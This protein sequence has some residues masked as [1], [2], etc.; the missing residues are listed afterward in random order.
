MYKGP[1]LYDVDI[2]IRSVNDLDMLKHLLKILA[3]EKNAH[4]LN[5]I[6]CEHKYILDGDDCVFEHNKRGPYYHK[7][8]ADVEA[9]AAAV[10]AG[11]YVKGMFQPKPKTSRDASPTRKKAG[12]DEDIFDD[13]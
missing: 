9:K 11:T 2:T 7:T 8:R 12:D 4:V 1:Q 13:L 6:S 5:R 3:D 10:K